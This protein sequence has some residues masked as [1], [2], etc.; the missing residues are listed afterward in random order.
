[1]NDFPGARWWRCDFHN[2]SPASFDVPDK[3]TTPEQWLLAYAQAGVEC[4]AITDHNSGAWIDPLQQALTNLESSGQLRPGQ[5]HLFPG[6]EIS[7]NQGV[8]V[9]A[10]FDPGTPGSKISQLL[11]LVKYRGQEG[12]SDAVTEASVEQVICEIAGLG[13]CAAEESA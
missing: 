5:L 8:H 10:I 11:G 9:L 7:A 2:H 13:A 3:S 1:M 6:V 4:V 12:D